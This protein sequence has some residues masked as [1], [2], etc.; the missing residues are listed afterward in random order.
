MRQCVR[1][2]VVAISAVVCT[3]TINAQQ[4]ESQTSPAATARPVRPVRL[5]RPSSSPELVRANGIGEWRYWAADAWSTRYSPLDQINAS[6]FDSLKIMW[7]W[8]AG[9]FGEDEYDR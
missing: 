6:N 1:A 2:V 9:E 3:Q 4:R 7:Q 8:N 5:A